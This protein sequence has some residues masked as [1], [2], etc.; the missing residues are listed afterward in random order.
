MLQAAINARIEGQTHLNPSNKLFIPIAAGA[1]VLTASRGRGL[2]LQLLYVLFACSALCV[3]APGCDRQH[4]PDAGRATSTTTQHGIIKV[5]QN[6]LKLA[7]CQ[8][9]SLENFLHCGTTPVT[10]LHTH[11]LWPLPYRASSMYSVL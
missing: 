2:C 9:P 1:G 4:R 10:S 8:A 5:Q 11:T 6:T 3:Q 7:R